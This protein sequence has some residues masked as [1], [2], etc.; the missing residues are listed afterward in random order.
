L[1][2]IPDSVF[3][4][5]YLEGTIPGGWSVST[6]E[7]FYMLVPSLLLLARRVP[8]SKHWIILTA[9]FIALPV[10]R[11]LT[12]FHFGGSPTEPLLF[13]CPIHTHADGLV[14]GLFIAR[15]S[16]ALP[17]VVERRPFVSNLPL[18]ALLVASGLALHAVSKGLFSY[19][20]LALIYAACALFVLRDQSL[21][22]RLFSWRGFH[23]VSRLS[24]AMYLNHFVVLE[25]LPFDDVQNKTHYFTTAYFFGYAMVLCVSAG[26]SVVTFL[27][28][29][30]P[31]LQLRDRWLVRRPAA[32][33]GVPV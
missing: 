25:L 14:T 3:L 12:I 29:E 10:S 28:I 16:V 11:A 23:V 15:C 2:F 4:T 22:T 17:K 1:Q 27:L 21:L 24:Y 33:A 20:A 9:M 30:S 31:F 19:S 6:E 26:I 7:Q 5:N 18:P 32:V 13:Y 8:L